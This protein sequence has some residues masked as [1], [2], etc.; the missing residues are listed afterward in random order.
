MAGPR[1]TIPTQLVLRALLTDPVA[2][3]TGSRSARPQACAAAPSTRSGAAR[4]R[5]LARVAVGG[6]GPVGRRAAGP[7]L[8][9][10]DLV[11]RGAGPGSAGARRPG[12]ARVA[13]AAAGRR[14][15]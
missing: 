15:A 5:G 11:R 8:L 10:P 7:S 1:M 6:R 12:R 3:S 14:A 4:G 13:P 2:S 9:P